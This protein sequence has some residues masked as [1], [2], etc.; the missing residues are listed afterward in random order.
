MGLLAAL[1]VIMVIV[2]FIVLVR[3]VIGLIY[4]HIILSHSISSGI[5]AGECCNQFT[6]T[7][8]ALWLV[9][10]I[11]TVLL[12]LCLQN[13]SICFRLVGG[14]LTLFYAALFGL[15]A[16]F[17]SEHDPIRRL[18]IFGLVFLGVGALHLRT[19]DN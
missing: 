11:A 12:L 16:Y 8:P 18:L 14:L 7:H 15:L 17:I 2:L 4:G 6:A 3:W 9:I 19:R 1:G 5:A 10:G 13:T